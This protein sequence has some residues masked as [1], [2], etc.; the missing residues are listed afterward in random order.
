MSLVGFHRIEH[1]VIKPKGSQLWLH[2][3]EQ[4]LS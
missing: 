4:V 3:F 1:M 2:T